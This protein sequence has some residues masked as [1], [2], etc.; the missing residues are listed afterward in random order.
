MNILRNEAPFAAQDAVNLPNPMTK[1]GLL[2]RYENEA[3]VVRL[4]TFHVQRRT[5][6]GFWV[7]SNYDCRVKRFVLNTGRKR[8]AYPTE[9]LAKAS[10][11]A[12]K[13]RQ[14]GLLDHQLECARLALKNI[15]EDRIGTKSEF[16]FYG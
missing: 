16:H 7:R 5:P 12:R 2:Y 4:R 13:E 9:D 3:D 10:F 14:I 8:F 1:V 15:Q 11:I 6:K